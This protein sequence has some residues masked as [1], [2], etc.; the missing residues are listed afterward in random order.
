M[1]LNQKTMQAC[2]PKRLDHARDETD[3]TRHGLISVHRGLSE[4]LRLL[5]EPQALS[6]D[7]LVQE[8][9]HLVR[10][11]IRVDLEKNHVFTAG[12]PVTP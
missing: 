4:R 6:L 8:F 11:Q 2:L 12:L 1:A 7:E 5:I 10:N 3:R 9:V